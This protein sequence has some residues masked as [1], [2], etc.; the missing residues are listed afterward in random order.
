[1][2]LQVNNTEFDQ[3][4]YIPSHDKW[5]HNDENAKGGD[6]TVE[7]IKSSMAIIFAL[8]CSTSLGDLFPLVQETA[9]SFI[10]RL[11]GAEVSDSGFDYIWDEKTGSFDINDPDVEIYNLMGAKV[12][13][14][15]S[16]IYIYRKGNLMK[17]VMVP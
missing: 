11:A 9:K 3:W 14:P 15:S 2:S 10:L 6:V 7:D 8:D 5:G 17:K 4:I 16:G 12:T 1:M 13:N